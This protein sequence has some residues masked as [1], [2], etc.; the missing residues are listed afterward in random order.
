M[1]SVDDVFREQNMIKLSRRDR[2]HERQRIAYPGYNFS[3]I[4]KVC[5][6]SCRWNV[7]AAPKGNRSIAVRDLIDTL[8]EN[9]ARHPTDGRG[10]RQWARGVGLALAFLPDE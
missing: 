9:G 5:V 1:I 6:R 7:V 3:P 2:R 8:R 10:L 4:W